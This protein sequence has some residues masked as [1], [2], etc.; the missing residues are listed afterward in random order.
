LRDRDGALLVKCF[1]NCSRAAVL[2]AV[3][4]L[5]ISGQLHRATPNSAPTTSLPT[6]A[7]SPCEAFLRAAMRIWDETYPIDR[8]SAERRLRGRG[9]TIQLP[10]TLRCHPH[11]YHSGANIHTPAM[12]AGVFDVVGAQRAIHRTWIDPSTDA[13][14]SFDKPRLA[15]SPTSGCAARLGEVTTSVALAE[16]IE[17][18]LALSQLTGMPAW[19]TL[20]TSGMTG[21]ILPEY[22][23]DVVIGADHDTA[24]IAAAN[25]LRARLLREGRTVC[26]IMPP[27]PGWDFNDHL[28]GEKCRG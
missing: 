13:I 5:L 14:A 23:R 4:G 17:T 25:E 11:L 24:G 18:S 1:K 21:V 9:I 7:V 10:N 15:L 12:V 26:V 28:R 22:V 19:A 27:T 2:N 6:L 16:G 3:T 8:T 20:S